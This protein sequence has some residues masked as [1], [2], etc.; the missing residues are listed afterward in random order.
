MVS[1]PQTAAHIGIF[2]EADLSAEKGHT[3]CND[4]GRRKPMSTRKPA[5]RAL[6]TG[7]NLCDAAGFTVRG[8]APV[9][10]LCRVLLETG[11]DPDRPLNAY[12]G[13]VLSFVVRTI[14]KG[15]RLT[16]KTAGSGCPVFALA[17][18]YQELNATKSG[19]AAS[20]H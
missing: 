16:V 11:C 6:L 13:G 12:R 15:A 5:I 1:K 4:P 10:E 14:G 3:D 19:F 8:R 9:T 2:V 7:S 18:G 17:E 20:A